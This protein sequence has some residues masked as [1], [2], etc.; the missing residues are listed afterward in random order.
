MDAARSGL[1]GHHVYCMESRCAILVQPRYFAEQQEL[2]VYEQRIE[3]IAGV[4]LCSYESRGQ[5]GALGPWERGRRGQPDT[6]AELLRQTCHKL[7]WNEVNVQGLPTRAGLFSL[8]ARFSDRLVDET[9]LGIKTVLYDAQKAVT[10]FRCFFSHYAHA[11]FIRN[12]FN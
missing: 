3:R 9:R 1:T 2:R 7:W 11:D 6:Q 10:P 12:I 4:Y 5:H 8:V